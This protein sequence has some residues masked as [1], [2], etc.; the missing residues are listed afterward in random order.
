MKEHIP[1]FN[2]LVR[3]HMTENKI[4]IKRNPEINFIEIANILRGIA[5]ELESKQPDW[6]T[7]I[8]GVNYEDRT[9]YSDGV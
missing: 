2:D 5:I 7:A 3:V 4:I 9:D 8:I 6:D 1:L